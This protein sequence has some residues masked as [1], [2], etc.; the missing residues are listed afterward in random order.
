MP[1]NAAVSFEMDAGAASARREVVDGAVG[2][3]AGGVAD[4]HGGQEDGGEI[5]QGKPENVRRCFDKP[6]PEAIAEITS[7]LVPDDVRRCP[8][9]SPR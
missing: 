7:L 8:R 9:A 1:V 5:R 4:A 6:S 2:V 3:T